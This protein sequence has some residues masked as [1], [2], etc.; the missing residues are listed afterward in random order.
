MNNPRAQNVQQ[1]QA[2]QGDENRNCSFGSLTPQIFLS[3]GQTPQCLLSSQ[4]MISSSNYPS[5]SMLSMPHNH[6]YAPVPSPASSSATP[7]SLTPPATMDQGIV[8]QVQN[9]KSTASLG[10][11][12]DLRKIALRARNVEYDPKKSPAVIMRIR[13]TQTTARIFS[14]GKIVCTGAKSEEDS[15]LAA[16]KHARIIQKLGF[17]VKFKDFKIQKIDF[18]M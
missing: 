8:P 9:I 15:R 2:P 16:R 12:L 5:T 13:E 1:C 14:S 18:V 7:L 6:I 4:S 11:Q 17:P 3:S 10:C